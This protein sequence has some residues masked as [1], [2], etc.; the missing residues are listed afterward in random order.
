[1]VTAVEPD[2]LDWMLGMR[3]YLTAEDGMGGILKEKPEDFIVEELSTQD[4]SPDGG[5][6]ILN[7]EKR[8]W[9]MH[10]LV[11]AISRILRIS[12]N[13][14]N[15]AGTKDKRALT[16]QRISIWKVEEQEI[17]RLRLEGVKLDVIGRSRKKVALG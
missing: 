4:L 5:Y 1:M 16:R 2:T 9:E 15:W 10:N 7:L 3:F 12:K 8:D 6:L 17:E 14:I 13:R 11:R